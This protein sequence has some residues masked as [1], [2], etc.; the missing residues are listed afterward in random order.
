MLSGYRVALMDNAGTNPFRITSIRALAD[1]PGD[2]GY[3]REHWINQ[4]Q[5]DVKSKDTAGKE[6][7]DDQAGSYCN[8]EVGFVYQALPGQGQS[9]RAKNIVSAVMPIDSS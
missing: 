3:P 1:E 6:V 7:G 8:M 2:K 4:G 9:L 5:S